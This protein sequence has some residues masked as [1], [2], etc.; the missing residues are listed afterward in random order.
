MRVIVETITNPTDI[1]SSIYTK[2]QSCRK[3]PLKLFL[4]HGE[5]KKKVD[6]AFRDFK[7]QN[8]VVPGNNNLIIIYQ[9][10]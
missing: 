10:K 6:W 5:G 3:W 1:L 9:Y 2:K 4:K 7:K 8:P